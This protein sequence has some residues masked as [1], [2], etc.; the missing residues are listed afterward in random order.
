MQTQKLTKKVEDTQ[1]IFM[2]RLYNE[3]MNMLLDAQH[4]FTRYGADDQRQLNMVH[5]LVYTSEMSR[6]TLRLSTVMAWIMA[7]RAFHS[8]QISMQDILEHYRLE[9]EDVCL[10]EGYHFEHILPSYVMQLHD[11]SRKLYARILALDTVETQ[12]HSA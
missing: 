11:A 4:Y 8:G 5:K 2:P 10:V 6:I 9:F 12:I 1:L 3:T 7:R